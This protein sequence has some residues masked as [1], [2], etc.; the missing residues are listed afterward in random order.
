MDVTVLGMPFNGIGTRPD[1]ENPARA[2]RDAGLI[3]RLEERGHRAIDLGD[4]PVPGFS[5]RRDAVTGVL[6]R[7]AWL[8]MTARLADAL[9]DRLDPRH[10]VV[11]LG[12]DCAI[13]SGVAAAAQAEL[14][15]LSVLYVDGHADYRMPAD[16]PSGEPADLVLTALT[17]RIPGLFGDLVQE[18]LARDEDLVA[19]GF[20]DADRIGESAIATFDR[21]R[22]RRMGM[23]RA[24]PDALGVLAGPPGPAWVHFD[25]DVLDPSAMP[26][27][28]FPERDGLS[29]A[30]V[31]Q[32]L[33]EAFRRLRVAGM[34]VACYHPLL[35]PGGAGARLIVELVAAALP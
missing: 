12:G 32:V 29:A 15:G 24:L 3:A 19:F 9:R 27:V 8:G 34:S 25:V 2:V 13:M 16:S 30:E 6:N 23:D 1:E 20:R 21:A 18:P 14:R 11:L 5:G 26:A 10:R 31:K 7:D 17:G 22:I 33:R 4:L 28:V 35:D